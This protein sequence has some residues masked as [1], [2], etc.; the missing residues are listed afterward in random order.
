MHKPSRKTTDHAVVVE[1]LNVSYDGTSV[2]EDI[3]LSIEA[4]T[5]AALI[6]PNGSGK[7]TL[8]K[9]MLDLIK[10]DGGEIFFFGEP[11]HNN[12]HRVGYVPQRFQFQ[13]DFPITVREFM[14]LAANDAHNG[15][16][17]RGKLKEA[18][19]KTSIEHRRLGTLSGGQL[20]RVLMAQAILNDPSVLFL[21]EPST[22]IDIVGEAEFYAIL[23]HLKT[24]H[25]T[26][27]ILVSHDVGMVGE[28]VDQVICV[29]KRL[30][31]T[32][33]PQSTLNDK[34][35]AELYGSDVSEYHHRCH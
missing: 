13:K 34:Q 33:P 16:H 24:K 35:L 12:R 8:L 22:G 23:H 2:L 7:T 14:E 5:I 27:V 3:S 25:S 17:I 15:T 26:T 28:M 1:H 21:D 6:G 31:C 30:L 29:N 9:A 4:G 32:G 19:L 10:I 11:L 18:G 20:Q